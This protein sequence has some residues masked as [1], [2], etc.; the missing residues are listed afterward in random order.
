MCIT[1]CNNVCIY[2][3]PWNRSTVTFMCACL[4]LRTLSL[5]SAFCSSIHLNRYDV[6]SFSIIANLL[7]LSEVSLFRSGFYSLTRTLVLCPICYHYVVFVLKVPYF[8]SLCYVGCCSVACLLARSLPFPLI[9]PLSHHSLAYE[10]KTNILVGCCS[11]CSHRKVEATQKQ[12]KKQPQP[13][14]K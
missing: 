12:Y 2:F 14:M 10:Y 4:G 7:E 9:L 13:E 5:W 6:Q 1:V 3:S 11:R 8:V